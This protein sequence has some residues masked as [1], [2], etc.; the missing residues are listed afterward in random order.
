MIGDILGLAGGGLLVKDAYDRLGRVG[1]QGMTAGGALAQQGLQQTQFKPFTVTS[2]LGGIQ[3][4]QEG[5]SLNLSDQQQALQN[6]LGQGAQGMFSSAMGDM[7]GREQEIYDRIRAMQ[8]PEE[9]RQRLALESRLFNQGRGGVQTSMFGGTP[10]QLAMAKAQS[11]AQNQAALMAMQQ[12]MQQQA[13]QAN[14]GQQFMQSQYLPQAAML[15]LLSPGLQ[16][17]ELQQRGQLQGANLF[18]QGTASGLDMLLASSL[19]QSNLMGSLGTGLLGG[20][21]SSANSP[22]GLFDFFKR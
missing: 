14:L 21:F 2:G 16:L 1:E 18:G 20:A 17:S 4:G 12:A 9:E 15:Q 8:S 19:G 22:G 6:L 13:Q 10:E 7:A 5:Y 11:E 3:A